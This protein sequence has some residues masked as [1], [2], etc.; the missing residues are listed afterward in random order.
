MD[1]VVDL[2]I[3]LY[4]VGKSGVAA[5]KYI[6]FDAIMA[7]PIMSGTRQHIKWEESFQN[8]TY[9]DRYATLNTAATRT[10]VE[11]QDAVQLSTVAG[12]AVYATPTFNAL[13]L[14]L[15]GGITGITYN[16][17]DTFIYETTITAITEGAGA[18]A[19]QQG[20]LFLSDAA[21]TSGR[22]TSYFGLRFTGT[23]ASRTFV[24]QTWVSG[25]LSLEN[26]FGSWVQAD[27]PIGI[28]MVFDNRNRI[29]YYQARKYGSGGEWRTIYRSPAAYEQWITGG[30][31]IPMLTHTTSANNQTSRYTFSNW[32][33][34]NGGGVIDCHG[35]VG[36]ST[37]AWMGEESYSADYPLAEHLAAVEDDMSVYFDVPSPNKPGNAM[38]LRTKDFGGDYNYSKTFYVT[39]DDT[40]SVGPSGTD[41]YIG[42]RLVFDGTMYYTDEFEIS[43]VNFEYEVI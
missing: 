34:D 5:D 26:A 18:G 37:G 16:M 14:Y 35:K 4:Y 1:T 22:D 19:W 24:R 33:W 10:I 29:L 6:R 40:I 23:G 11:T 32:T 7:Y 12:Q 21:A 42:L 8:G 39:D 17:Q 31:A 36:A 9:L 43:E 15:G 3:A 30:Y 2:N 20:G 41:Q 27:L 25:A 38:E 28:R 13:C